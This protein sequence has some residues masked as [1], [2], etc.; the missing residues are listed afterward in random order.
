LAKFGVLRGQVTDRRSL[1]R[2]FGQQT[3]I[4]FLKIVK[5]TNK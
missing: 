5:K 4:R 3:T 2:H 1:F